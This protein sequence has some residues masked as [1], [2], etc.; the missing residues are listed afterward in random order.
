M[1]K[2][3]SDN[4]PAP[5]KSGTEPVE[6]ASRAEIDAFVQRARTLGP[7]GFSGPWPRLS[8]WHGAADPVQPLPKCLGD[9]LGLGL[10][11]AVPAVPVQTR[12]R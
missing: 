10:P 6:R 4:A 7:T 11:G 5:A 12:V 2:D 9:R 8:I 1:A 3:R